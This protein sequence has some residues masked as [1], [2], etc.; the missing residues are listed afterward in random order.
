MRAEIQ[1]VLVEVPFLGWALTAS[2][3][4]L[5][6]AALATAA[7]LLTAAAWRAARARA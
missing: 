7:A 2:S 6:S 4:R 1:Q 3:L 5:L